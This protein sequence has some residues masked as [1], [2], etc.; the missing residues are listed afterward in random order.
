MFPV[1]RICKSWNFQYSTITKHLTFYLAAKSRYLTEIAPSMG[2]YGK[3]SAELITNLGWS[4][5]LLVYQD[6]Q[7]LPEVADLLSIWHNQRG[8]RT[9][10]KVL[11]LPADPNHYEVF[12][13]YVRE[14]LRQTNLVIHTRDVGTIHSVLSAAS[15]LNMTESKY[16]FMFTNPVSAL[17]KLSLKPKLKVLRSSAEIA[18]KHDCILVGIILVKPTLFSGLD[19]P[20]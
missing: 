14:K 19:S 18:I 12:L 9:L 2:A 5:F 16:S 17:Q 10:L 15:F 20:R 6:V 4:S 8:T 1:R 3:A 11:Q 13:K 7:L